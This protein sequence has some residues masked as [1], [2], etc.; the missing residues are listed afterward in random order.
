[1]ESSSWFSANKIA[2]GGDS[3]VRI[4]KG[5]VI[6]KWNLPIEQVKLYQQITNGLTGIEFQHDRFRI[7][8]LP[9]DNVLKKG[10]AVFSTSQYVMGRTI[11]T[12]NPE[13]K[14][15][16]GRYFQNQLTPELSNITNAKG[17]NVITWNAMLLNDNQSVVVTD[18]ASNVSAISF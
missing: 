17:I 2:E 15:L 4:H 9:I 16:L 5:V 18:I 8:I 12:I 7:S 6:K 13:D 1:M 3:E 10:S 11:N 14:L